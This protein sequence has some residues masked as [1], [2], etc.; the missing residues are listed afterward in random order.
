MPPTA[1]E[2]RRLEMG[3]LRR[4]K[5]VSMLEATT[6]LL[7]VGVA[8]PLKHVAGWRM[9]VTMMGPVHGLA[10]LA[11]VWTAIQTVAGG[12]WSS[13]DIARLL[14]VAFI[15]FGGYANLAFLKRKAAQLGT[16]EVAA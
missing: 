7:L 9:G 10:F 4:L 16:P 14:V 15:P 8:V 13:R 12:G 5:I 6:L 1:D 11:Y 2:R 3:Q